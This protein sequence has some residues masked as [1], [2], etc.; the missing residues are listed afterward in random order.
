MKQAIWNDVV[1][2]ES[3]NTINIEGNHYFPLRSLN[4]EYITEST[5]ETVCHW[6]GTAN[7]FSLNVNGKLNQ[8]AVWYYETPKDAAK[9]IENRVAFWKGVEIVD[10]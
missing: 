8:D 3:D 10:I 5:T 6:K 9:V 4:K 2:A 1:I 7:Y